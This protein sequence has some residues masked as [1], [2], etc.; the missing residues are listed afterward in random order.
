MLAASIQ[1]ILESLSD[2]KKRGGKPKINENM[3]STKL[4]S[5]TLNQIKVK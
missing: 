1:D 4:V 5:Y 3:S 2:K